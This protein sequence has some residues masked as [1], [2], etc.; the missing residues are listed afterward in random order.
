MG[1][2][3]C[4]A[5]SF[6]RFVKSYSRKRTKSSC[7]YTREQLVTFLEN[8][9]TVID[10]QYLKSAIANYSR[11]CNQFNKIIDEYVRKNS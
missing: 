2:L 11:N 8:A 7:K 10:K 3:L 6:K 5:R 9:T 4:K 1:C